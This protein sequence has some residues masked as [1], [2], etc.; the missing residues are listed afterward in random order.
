MYENLARKGASPLE[1][2]VWLELEEGW[3]RLLFKVENE[4][5][6]FGIYARVLT[7]GVTVA[8]RPE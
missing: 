2:L 6:P 1:K 3:N 5:G 4:G 7:D 8:A